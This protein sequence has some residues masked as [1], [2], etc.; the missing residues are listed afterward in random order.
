MR[1]IIQT[2]GLLF[3][4]AVA[5]ANARLDWQLP[6]QGTDDYGVREWVVWCGPAGSDYTQAVVTRDCS[7]VLSN[8]T[9]GR[10]YRFGVT[11]LGAGGGSETVEVTAML[12]EEVLWIEEAEMGEPWRIVRSNV[13]TRTAGAGQ[14]IFRLRI[15]KK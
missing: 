11:A 9:P 3:A 5:G 14:R 1:G 2:F 13:V 8:L 7:C 15:G 6:L 10:L 4:L 12:L